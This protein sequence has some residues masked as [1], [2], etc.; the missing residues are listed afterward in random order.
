MNHIAHL[1]DRKILKLSGP[2]AEHFLQ[3]LITNDIAK[4]TK[5]SAKPTAIFAGLLTPQGKILFDFFIAPCMDGFFL[6]VPAKQ[7]HN[8]LKRLRFYKLRANLNIED[9]SEDFDVVYLSSNETNADL[10]S[11]TIYA[12]PRLGNSDLG[13]R[14][15]ITRNELQALLNNAEYENLHLSNYHALRIQLTVP[16]GELDYLYGQAF[17]FDAC[18]DLL[19]GIDFGKGCYVGQEVVSRMHHRGTARK[20]I[21]KV[22]SSTPL[23]PGSDIEADGRVI[24]RMGSFHE[25]VGIAI[26]RLD[27]AAKAIKENSPILV[28]DT[29]VQLSPPEWANYSLS[30]NED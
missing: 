24:G 5:N 20:R 4:I 14:G 23:T 15:V 27:K 22:I 1:T 7:T 2:D 6:D 30:E 11:G 25:G 26:V 17:A 3:G 19:N 8:I 12:D 21:A 29:P 13:W 28:S 18:Y 9:T 16:E 10:P